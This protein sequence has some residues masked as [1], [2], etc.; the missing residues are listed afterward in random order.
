MNSGIRVFFGGAVLCLGVAVTSAQ[1]PKAQPAPKPAATRAAAPQPAALKPVAAHPQDFTPVIKRYCV[2]CHSDKGKAGGLSL[3][4]FDAAHAAQNP[5]VAEKVIRKLQAG[6][7]PP[8]LS[9]RPDA[10]TSAALIGAL[11]TDIDTA[12]AI[13]PN[14]RR[15]HLPAPEPSGIHARGAVLL[16]LDVDAGSWLPLDSKS[17]NFDNIADAQALS[18]T[19]LEAHSTRPAVSAA[20]R[21]AIATRRRST[22]LTAVPATSR[23]IRGTT[24]PA[25]LRHA[26]RL[27][28][29]ARLPG[30]RGACSRSTWCRARTPGSRTSTSRSTASASR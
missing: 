7:M 15:A 19:L 20:W 23:S 14:L 11:E 8:P 2:G 28:R 6:F 22:P 4:A 18:P 9:P 16:A 17:A 10:S 26:R 27:G 30:R 1:S 13:K 21:S 5:E 12:S 24:S 29:R 25:R 3:A